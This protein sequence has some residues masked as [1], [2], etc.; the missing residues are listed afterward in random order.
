MSKRYPPEV[1][2]KGLFGSILAGLL[3]L[4][5]FYWFVQATYVQDEKQPEEDKL[6]AERK[7]HLE[8]LKSRQ[9]REATTYAWIDRSNEVVRLPIKR[10]M[11]LIVKEHQKTDENKPPKNARNQTN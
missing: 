3:F 5:V 9:E 2:S 6:V 8:N 4:L 1:I 7:A 10:A 11:E